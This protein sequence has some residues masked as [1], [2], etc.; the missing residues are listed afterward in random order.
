MPLCERCTLSIQKLRPQA[1]GELLRGEITQLPPDVKLNLPKLQYDTAQTC[2]L[3]LKFVQWLETED[4]TM[5]NDWISRPLGV[6]YKTHTRG[7]ADLP[8]LLL[9]FAISIVPE[10][11]KHH[12]TL[13]DAEVNFVLARDHAEPATARSKQHEANGIDFN[14]INN[15]VKQCSRNHKK[16]RDDSKSWYPTRLL[17]LDQHTGKIKLILT[18]SRLP[19]GQYMTLSHRWGPQSYTQLQP[20]TMAQLQDNVDV[21]TLPKIFQDAIGLAH[22]LSIRYLWIDALCIQ[23]GQSGTEDWKV[24]APR[25]G[26]VYSNAFINVSATFSWDGTGSLS[27]ERSWGHM[28][29]SKIDLDINGETLEYYIFDGDLWFDDVDNAPLSKRGWVFQERFLARRV[30]H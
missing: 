10:G 6:T 21:V 15:W 28:L 22:H 11:N 26:K 30:L 23:Q 8:K 29:P 3:C 17:H 16:C 20:S 7:S 9:P 18:K 25:M 4:P 1:A 24:E 2:W 12:E 5:F 13:F 14:L 27:Q 19:K